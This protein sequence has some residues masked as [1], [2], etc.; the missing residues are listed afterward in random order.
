VRRTLSMVHFNGNERN[1]EVF[2]NVFDDEG[3][4]L[5]SLNNLRL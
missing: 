3:K 5:W 1:N 4:P 2:Q